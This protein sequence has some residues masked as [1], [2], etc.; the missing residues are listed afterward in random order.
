MIDVARRTRAGDEV[1]GKD[2]SG[3]FKVHKAVLLVQAIH[4]GNDHSTHICT[5]LGHHGIPYLGMNV[6]TYAEATGKFAALPKA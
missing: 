5:V 6:W 2:R 1:E 4:H 3:R